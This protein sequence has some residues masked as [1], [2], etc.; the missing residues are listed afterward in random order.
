MKLRSPIR[1][2]KFVPSIDSL[3][4]RQLLT[5]SPITGR[6][7]IA[8]IDTSFNV[9][10][11]AIAG[12]LDMTHAYDVRAN[13]K[14]PNG[15]Y[16]VPGNTHGTDVTK[17]IVSQLKNMRDLAGYDAGIQILPIKVGGSAGIDLDEVSVAIQYAIDMGV[18][19]INIS[20]GSVNGYYPPEKRSFEAASA[21]GIVIVAAA[22]NDN[23]NTDPGT[24]RFFPAGYIQYGLT[25]MIT[26]ASLDS[27][28]QL[29]FNSNYGAA[30][31]TLGVPSAGPSTTAF[32]AGS[33]SGIVGG[34]AALRPNWTPAQLISRVKSTVSVVSQPAPYPTNW[35]TTNG[36][37]NPQAIVAGIVQTVAINSGSTTGAGQYVS[38]R[39]NSAGATNS[40]TSPINTTG[41]TLPAPQQ[42]YQTYRFGTFSYTIPNLQPNR[43]YTVT[44]DFAET[45]NSSPGQRLFGVTINGTSVL[46]NFDIYAAAGGINKA[47]SRVFTTQSTSTGTVQIDFTAPSGMSAAVS[48]IKVNSV[49]AV[50]QPLI[51]PNG[52]YQLIFQADGNLVEYGPNGA[53]WASN[54]G[55][56]PGTEA[57]LQSDG[58]LVIY[59][60]STPVWSTNTGGNP[61]AYLAVQD[62]GRVGIFHPAT[63]ALLWTSNNTLLPGKQLNPN[64]LISSPN[65]RFQL[66]MQTDGNLVVY[67]PSGAVWSTNTGGHPGAVVLM[68]TDGNLVVYNNSGTPIWSTGTH[69]RAGAYLV[70]QNDGKLKLIH[71]GSVI[72]SS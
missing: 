62:D 14:G 20:Y 17:N 65:G 48:G 15:S 30:S 7:L 69:G 44:L 43:L 34:L 58:N 26:V 28:N 21:A 6:V 32:A 1:R 72:W 39:F 46:S 8:N 22:G 4:N 18:S 25:N 5:I 57:I 9:N 49:L 59:S 12:F 68:Q 56:L 52:L 19:V 35:S 51:S 41:V 63:N 16:F 53:I 60:G 45:F 31:V 50:G 71:N 2:R 42:V 13:I 36:V 64:Q 29:A 38:D 23:L 47:V 33:V 54:T 40:V 61:G 11:P 55:G 27:S 66:L 37:I 70:L 10:D 24:N 3:E 67:G